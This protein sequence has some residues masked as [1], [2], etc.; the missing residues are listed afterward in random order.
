[1]S[2]S[3]EQVARYLREHP[4]F[5][6]AYAALLAEVEIPHPHGGRAISISE[7]QI[8]TLR[9]RNKLLEAKLAELIKFGEENDAIGE[10]IHRLA[11]ALVGAATLDAILDVL[12]T[13]LHDD[14]SVPHCTVR[15]WRPTA[16]ASERPELA[17]TAAELHQFAEAM[18]VP[19]CGQ[20]AVYEVNHWFGEAAPHLR[21][22]ALIPLR[23]DATLGLLV[24]ASE[25]A[26]RFYPEMGTLYLRR[27]GEL[28]GAALA[29]RSEGR[30]AAA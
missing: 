25:D 9:E 30:S 8:L 2:F 21:S 27:L 20:H 23:D 12:Y 3:P 11:V 17:E 7:R 5:F 19:Y 14:F 10:K 15:L 24:L 18:T 26:Q 1:M 4:E 28:A 29:A 6:E 22:F 13:S 16:G